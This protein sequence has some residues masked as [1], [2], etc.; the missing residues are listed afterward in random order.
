MFK[1]L[2]QKLNGVVK[3]FSKEVE[4]EA[5]EK[6]IDELTEEEKQELNKEDIEKE[7]TTETKKEELKKE[8]EKKQEDEENKKNKEEFES[9]KQTHKPKKE[10]N[11]DLLERDVALKKEAEEITT[12]KPKSKQNLQEIAQKTKEKESK[13]IE[14][15]VEKEDIKKYEDSI[16]PEES[17]NQENLK[18]IEETEEFDEIEEDNKKN[19]EK[20]SFFSKLFKRKTKEEQKID[21]LA[22][23][24]KQELNKEDIEKEKTT[25]T[26][27]EELKKETEKKQEDEENKKNKEE[28]TKISEDKKEKNIQKT[29]EK[30]EEP[31]T[32]NQDL[33]IEEIKKEKK[34]FFSK[35][36]DTFTK[37]QLSEEKFEELFWELELTLLENN[38]AL[39]VIDL[40][41]KDLKEE[42]TTGKLSRKNVSEIIQDTL[43][44]TLDKVLT[45]YQINLE[46]DIKKSKAEGNPYIIS[47]IGING[48]GKTTAIAKLTNKLKKEGFS[49][50]WAAADTF[51]AAAIQQ[52]EEHAN[53]LE[54]KLIKHD[55][56]S[57]PAAVAFDA[58][59]HAKAKKIDVVMIDTAGRMHSNDNLM[60]ELKK[61]IRVNPPNLKIYV[62]ESITGNDCV[63]QAKIYDAQIGIDAI[64]LT[65]AD[66][67]EKGG[68]AIS[69]SHVTGKPILF[70]G[71]GQKYEDLETFDKEKI[72]ESLGL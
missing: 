51:R 25:E 33:I 72:L 20:K 1:F 53:K 4:A 52:L 24:E 47:V 60:Q 14:H 32:K 15:R 54:I 34:S 9:N 36:S 21:E 50:V 49:I 59:K 17:K 58:I 27:K 26:K 62:G 61:L 55:Y 46:E 6:K 37:V 2:K 3:K 67:D 8:T 35:V 40:I 30:K 44:K 63:E 28:L 43:K 48:A 19:E 69:I 71:T 7:K 10:E 45:V 56:E 29:A 23:E 11:V 41:K 66:T 16:K 42:L 65:K 22:E 38:V 12:E 68:A 39:Q 70:L 57:D 64:I 31:E 18:E 5:E 13:K